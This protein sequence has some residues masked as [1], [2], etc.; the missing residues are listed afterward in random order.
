MFGRKNSACT[1][2][3]DDQLEFL[4]ENKELLIKFRLFIARKPAQ[5]E[6][7]ESPIKFASVHEVR[8]AEAD[9]KTVFNDRFL[10]KSSN[11]QLLD[12]VVR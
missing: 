3:D 4:K 2:I 5:R 6:I 12:R 10:I 9:R 1:P 8:R 11:R 7:Y